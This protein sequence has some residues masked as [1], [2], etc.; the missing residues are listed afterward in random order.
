MG[1]IFDTAFN[2]LL[3]GMQDTTTASG[4]ITRLT[5]ASEKQGKKWN[6]LLG[7]KKLL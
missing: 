4:I 6:Y 7:F 3:D 5:Y 2:E 1:M